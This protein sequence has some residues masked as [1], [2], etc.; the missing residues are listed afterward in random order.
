MANKDSVKLFGTKANPKEYYAVGLPLYLNRNTGY[1]SCSW[2]WVERQDRDFYFILEISD[3]KVIASTF[4]PKEVV[5]KTAKKIYKPYL[6][7]I[8]NYRNP[9]KTVT[10]TRQFP[11]ALIPKEIVNNWRYKLEYKS[12]RFS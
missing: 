7:T 8:S 1:Y 12:S 5:L 10:V 4:V 3:D 6:K 2:K 9:D 11:I